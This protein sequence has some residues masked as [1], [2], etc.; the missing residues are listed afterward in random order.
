MDRLQP[1]S[2]SLNTSV[3]RTRGDGPDCEQMRSTGTACSPHTR[4]WTGLRDARPVGC[5]PVPRTRGDGPAWRRRSSW[6]GNC[7]P[8]T[9]G[10]TA[11]LDEKLGRSCLFPAHAGMDR[12]S[13]RGNGHPSTVPRTRGDGPDSS[14]EVPSST[15]LFPAHAGMDRDTPILAATEPHCSPHTRGWTE[16]RALKSI[17][18]ALFP[19]HAGMDRN[20]P[21]GQ[22]SAKT[23]SPHTRGWTEFTRWPF[24]YIPTVPRTR[25]DGPADVISLGVAV[26]LFP[27]HAGM[28]R[29]R[30]CRAPPR[31]CCSPHTRGWT[32]HVAMVDCPGILFP[33]HAGMDRT[34][35]NRAP[36]GPA[37]SPHTRGWT[38]MEQVLKEAGVLFP[39]HAGMDRCS[40]PARWAPATVPRTRGDGP[41]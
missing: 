1:V 39:A 40:K 25:G 29:T 31:S 19:A 9:R 12:R 36:L 27:A 8:H 23:C 28:D 34:C 35:G 22:S 11:N 3:P 17:F 32:A 37:C 18:G 5:E 33:A 2:R 24:H 13:T 6:V 4:G 21:A 7:S 26:T 10:W 16:T 20:P 15:G 38:V 14:D 30:R 41:Q